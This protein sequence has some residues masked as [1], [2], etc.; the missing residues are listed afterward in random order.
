[1]ATDSWS[2][3][4]AACK[5]VL[6]PLLPGTAHALATV[7][8]GFPFDTV[9]TRLQVGMHS[10]VFDCLRSTLSREGARALYRGAAMPLVSLVVKRP[11]EF[12][13]FE[14]INA[15]SSAYSSKSSFMGGSVAGVIAAVLGCPFSVMKIQMQASRRDTYRNVLQVYRDVLSANGIRGF[16]RG[17]GA[18]LIMTVP[19]T[20]FY[21][22]TYG[23]LREK[24]PRSRWN[25]ALAGMVASISMWT[26]LLP[27]D[28]VRTRI[29][30]RRFT[31][32]QIRLGWWA[33]FKNIIETRGVLGLWAGWNSLLVRAPL[34]SAFSMLAYEQ[35][36]AFVASPTEHTPQRSATP[37]VP[38]PA[39]AA[40]AAGQLAVGVA[41]RG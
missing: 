6:A 31:P 4:R 21:L 37:V 12:A 34:V 38:M 16:Y 20:T 24:L 5:V 23:M 7:A 9:K 15:R 17:F 40:V 29:Q 13:A 8:V 10:S 14:A 11:A 18:Q 41:A 35:A 26:C 32:D 19:S 33:Q 25:T 27:L 36:R 28:N 22:G 1:M 30:A 2:R 39:V 3:Q